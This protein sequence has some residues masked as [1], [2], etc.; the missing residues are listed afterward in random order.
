MVRQPESEGHLPACGLH[1]PEKWLAE[2]QVGGR[3]GG[4]GAAGP[5]EFLVQPSAAQ[6]AD[7]LP[8]VDDVDKAAP[9]VPTLQEDGLRAKSPNRPCRSIHVVDGRNWN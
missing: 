5:V 4:E 3:R 6:V 8:V 2:C 9:H 1:R 7:A